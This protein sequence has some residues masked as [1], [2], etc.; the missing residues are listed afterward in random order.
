MIEEVRLLVARIPRAR[1]ITL[2]SDNHMPL[3]QEPAFNVLVDA[4]ERFI[5]ESE[6]ADGDRHTTGQIGPAEGTDRLPKTL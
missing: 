2:D 6:L 4:I 3:P 1:L 5:G